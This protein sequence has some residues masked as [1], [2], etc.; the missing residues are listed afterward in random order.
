M[1]G[2]RA[3]LAC[4]AAL[5]ASAG[6]TSAQ[7]TTT[8]DTQAKGLGMWE[9]AAIFTVGEN[10]GDFILPGIPDGAGALRTDD[11]TVRV[12]VNHELSAPE[13]YA[14][15]LAN[16]TQLTG[17][18]VTVFD[19][20]AATRALTGYAPAY[21][22]IYDRYGLEVVSGTQINEGVGA[23]TEGLDRFC[24]GWM[25]PAGVYGLVDDIYFCGEEAT[26]GSHS[27]KRKGMTISAAMRSVEGRRAHVASQFAGKNR[28][29]RAAASAASSN[30]GGIVVRSTRD[31]TT[32]P[33]VSI[34]TR[35]H[36]VPVSESGTSGRTVS[37]IEG[38]YSPA[39][40][41]PDASR[42]MTRTESM[43]GD[44]DSRRAASGCHHTPRPQS[45]AKLT[46]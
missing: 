30:T 16:G 38:M 34:A 24:S 29:R 10:D 28:Q 9:T 21:E 37:S 40:N 6:T 7:L 36:T 31:S 32:T 42:S 22:T 44:R 2:L 25:G 11:E 19:L 8:E 4:L 13:G 18:R 20:D 26:N 41:D 33:H 23:V 14:Y 12:W 5:A 1:S 46:T 45:Q 27:S 17:A 43:L 35:T 39:K 15:D 3:T